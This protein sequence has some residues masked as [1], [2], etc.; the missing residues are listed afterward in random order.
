MG[1]DMYAYTMTRQPATAVDFAFGEDEPTEIFY[2]RKHPNLH[3][4][5]EDLYRAKG[6]TNPDF[7]LAP[8]A[9]TKDDIDRLEADVRANRL[10]FTDGCFFGQSFP[11]DCKDDLA[12]I[13]EARQALAANLVVFYYAWW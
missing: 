7:N 9:L 5:M 12:F 11:E 13:A 1:L 4:W 3:G 10:P 8:L 6:G 2:W